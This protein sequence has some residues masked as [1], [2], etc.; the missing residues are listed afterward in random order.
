MSNHQFTAENAS[1]ALPALLSAILESP[2]EIGS[3]AGRVLELT[4]VGIKLTR[5]E[6]RYITTPM[7]KVNLVAQIAETMWVLNGHDSVRYLGTYLP[8]APE[9]SDDGEVWRGAYGPRIRNWGGVDQLAHVVRLLTDDRASRRAVINIYDPTIDTEDGKDIPCNNWLHFLNRDGHLDMHV[10]IR[11]NDAMWGWSGINAFEWSALQEILAAILG[12]RVGALHFS[13]SSLHVYQ[14]YWSKSQKI[15]EASEGI[16]RM[17][18]DGPRAQYR[19]DTPG[20][21]FADFLNQMDTWF[22]IEAL[23]VGA[24]GAG[25]VLPL[26]DDL[27]DPLLRSWAAIIIDHHLGRTALNLLDFMS[28]TSGIFSAYQMSPKAKVGTTGLKAIVPEAPVP[29]VTQVKNADITGFTK[30]VADLH[31][32]KDAVYGDSWKKR[33]EQIGIMANIARKVDR[34]GEAGGG[35]TAADTVID[36]LVYLVKY[37]LYTFD[38]HQEG[39]VAGNLGPIAAAARGLVGNYSLKLNGEC[40][41]DRGLGYNVMS[42]SNDPENVTNYLY[43]LRDKVAYISTPAEVRATIAKV[44]RDFDALEEYVIADRANARDSLIFS[45]IMDAFPLAFAIWLY[46]RYDEEWSEVETSAQRSIAL[47]NS[48]R[49]WE[50]Y[51]DE[52]TI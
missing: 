32:E 26:L 40:V 24:A 41:R 19:G 25:A 42:Y 39:V 30:F 27:T 52:E 34:L 16:V 46:D 33:G 45:M 44:R 7:R 49:R 11:S 22:E 13:I 18:S 28:E 12:V 43:W 14:Q 5:P 15:V 6:D 36:L 9:F 29:E 31:L 48:T 35:D 4:Q 3:R 20:D 37:H 38:G 51:E 47:R 8:R 1:M 21:R 17:V 10:A 50:G 2:D 23:S